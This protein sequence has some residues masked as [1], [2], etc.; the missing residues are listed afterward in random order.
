ML[1]LFSGLILMANYEANLAKIEEERHDLTN[2][3]K[4]L[5][6]PVTM[7]PEATK[8]QKEMQ[9]LRQ[10]Y[11]VFEAQKVGQCCCQ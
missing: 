8:I 9:G 10:I 1:F 11:Q 6:L 4:L 5:N 3:E 2:A 7:Y